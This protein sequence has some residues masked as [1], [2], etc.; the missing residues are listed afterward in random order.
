MRAR[1]PQIVA[2]G[3]GGFST[4]VRRLGGVAVLL[5]LTG[6]PVPMVCF[7]PTASGDP[8]EQL[9][10]FHERFC[11]W[12]CEPSPISVF[13][14]GRDRIDPVA[15]LLAHDA[16]YVGGGS[17]RNM[18]AICLSV[19]LDAELRVRLL[20]EADIG[21]RPSSERFAVSE[22]RALRAGRR[23]WD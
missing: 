12:P 6:K 20:P 9:A 1:P 17:M 11:S 4:G 8:R 22:R 18:L 23:R 2:F 5:A 10:R 19:H 14:L 7:L 16:V 3:G 21:T 13:H 15:H